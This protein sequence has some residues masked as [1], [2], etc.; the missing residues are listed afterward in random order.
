M[1]VFRLRCLYTWHTVSSLVERG[2]CGLRLSNTKQLSGLDS[3]L[4][5]FSLLATPFLSISISCLIK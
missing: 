5:L 3:N 1:V 2:P 4:H